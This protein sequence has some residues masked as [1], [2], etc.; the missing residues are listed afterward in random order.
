MTPFIITEDSHTDRFDG[1]KMD[2]IYQVNDQYFHFFEEQVK[3]LQAEKS[4]GI[5]T[6]VFELLQLVGIKQEGGR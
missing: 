3:E 6:S 4:Q 5:I 2:A 1:R